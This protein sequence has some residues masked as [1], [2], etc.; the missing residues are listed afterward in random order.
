[1]GWLALCACLAAGLE[2]GASRPNAAALSALVRG[3][4][5]FGRMGVG[6]AAGGD[7]FAAFREAR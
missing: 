1:M 3:L 5:L 4:R 2:M 6:N 7:S